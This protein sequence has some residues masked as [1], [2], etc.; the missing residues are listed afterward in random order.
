MEELNVRVDS[1]MDAN[2]I[3]EELREDIIEA[4]QLFLWWKPDEGEKKMGLVDRDNWTLTYL[5]SDGN[6]QTIKIPSDVV[7]REKVMK[8]P[9]WKIIQWGPATDE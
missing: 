7:M 5:G 8:V 2:N 9:K 3:K 4:F 1:F 6:L